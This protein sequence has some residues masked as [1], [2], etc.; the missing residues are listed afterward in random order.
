MKHFQGFCISF[1][2]SHFIPENS[3]F[4]THYLYFLCRYFFNFSRF[5]W[6]FSFNDF[7]EK[8]EQK[9]WKSRTL[10][11][12][13]NQWIGENPFIEQWDI[14]KEGLLIYTLKSHRKM[15]DW[16]MLVITNEKIFQETSSLPRFKHLCFAIVSSRPTTQTAKIDTKL[17][18]TK[19][20]N[21]SPS[22]TLSCIGTVF[23]KSKNA[24]SK[25]LNRAESEFSFFHV[26]NRYTRYNGEI[27]QISN[28]YSIE[29]IEYSFAIKKKWKVLKRVNRLR[30][31]VC[32]KKSITVW[33][34]M[35][36]E[37]F[38]PQEYY[39]VAYKNVIKSLQYK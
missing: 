21:Y 11:R 7:I 17:K 35:K 8:W 23:G 32:K 24:I 25:S 19:I 14:K 15:D 10:R 38:V 13:W 20:I 12:I 9:W 6:D 39:H 33:K 29:Y 28:Y 3:D 16:R 30:T 37:K 26:T 5:S 18:D 4:S 27:V 1:T 31:P 2:L 22:R 34:K 36:G